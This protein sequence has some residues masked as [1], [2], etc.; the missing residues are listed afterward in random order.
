MVDR[1]M[2]RPLDLNGPLIV[3]RMAAFG[4][5]RTLPKTFSVGLAVPGALQFGVSQK[6]IQAL[7]ASG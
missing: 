3:S 2:A 1:E 7:E 6:P 5:K 4:A